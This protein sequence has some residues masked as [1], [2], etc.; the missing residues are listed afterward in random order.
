MSLRESGLL[1]GGLSE[2]MHQDLQGRF[3]H[4]SANGLRFYVDTKQDPL[5]E[6]ETRVYPYHDEASDLLGVAASFGVQFDVA[7]DSFA[8]GGHSLLP[9]LSQG[10]ARRG[11]GFDI[12]PRAVNLARV[13]AAQNLID[14][15]EFEVHDVHQGLPRVEG[16]ALY[17]ANAPF[18]I[19]AQGV[20]M[21]RMRDGG[22][23]GLRLARAFINRALIESYVEESLRGA[24]PG[25][26][27]IGV[28]YS[29]IG[30]NG[31]VELTTALRRLVRE[32]SFFSSALVEGRKLWRGANG[33]KEQDNPMNLDNMIVKA[34]PGEDYERQLQAYRD[35]IEQHREQ[36]FNRLGYFSY[37]IH[38]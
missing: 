26:I 10:I 24:K 2:A 15:A 12:N 27:V 25:D 16:R 17:L 23:D 28:A 13:N 31:E 6:G 19:P 29:R 4:V 1:S 3:E 9:I 11:F 38:V 37:V 34:E 20:E 14:Q 18:A 5:G 7:V 22:H 36:G 32:N 21:D 30:F 8:G 33:R 35:A